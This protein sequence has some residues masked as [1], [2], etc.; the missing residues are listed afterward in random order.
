MRIFTKV[1]EAGSFTKAAE[2][3]ALPK[4]TVS[5]RVS[6]LED[7]LGTLLLQRTTRKLTLTLSGELFY[8]RTSH[9]VEELQQAQVALEELQSAPRGLLRITTPAD[10]ATMIPRLTGEFQE[11]YPDVDVVVFAT[12]RRVDLVA[13]GYDLALRAGRLSD[14]SMVSKKLLS[15][16]FGVYASPEYLR[17]NGVPQTPSDL[18]KHRCLCFGT[19]RTSSTWILHGPDGSQEVSVTGHLASND[20]SVLRS[21]TMLGQGVAVLPDF[22]TRG[23]TTAGR[24]QQILPEFTSDAGNLYAVY[25]SARHV[26]PKVRAFVDFATEWMSRCPG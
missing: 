10:M 11:L 25:P 14:S 26:S 24:L 2:Q 4:S 21:A 19:D 16:R 9:I 22:D 17:I 8:A 7:Q 1:V 23:E 12:G 3:L 20:F 15:S 5:R 6:D 18:T 13:E